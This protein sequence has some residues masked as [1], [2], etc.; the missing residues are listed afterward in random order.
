MSLP[1]PPLK[2]ELRLLPSECR[3]EENK[4]SWEGDEGQWLRIN[5]KAACDGDSRV[6]VLTLKFMHVLPMEKDEATGLI[7]VVL[8]HKYS[9]EGLCTP[10]FTWTIPKMWL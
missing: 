5:D 2:A 6:L 3:E 1:L 8:L 10:F 9:Y 7:D 4:R